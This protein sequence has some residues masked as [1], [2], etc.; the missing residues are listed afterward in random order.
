[1]DEKQG[2]RRCL[3]GW[4]FTRGRETAKNGLSGN[5]VEQ[6]GGGSWAAPRD[7]KV[8]EG[9]GPTGRRRVAGSSPA[10]VFVGGTCV[11]STQSASKH[12]RGSL[13]GGPSATVSGGAIRFDLDSYSNEFKRNSNY[14]KI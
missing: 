10:A 13:M 3:G 5:G 7:E 9:P 4:V 2:A 14:F 6:W 11:G 12:E 8:G 1:V